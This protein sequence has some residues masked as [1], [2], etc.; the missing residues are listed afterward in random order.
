[1][2]FCLNQVLL[3][4]CFEFQN[5]KKVS[6]NKIQVKK[7]KIKEF[8]NLENISL[9]TKIE[10]KT[11]QRLVIN[12]FGLG[13]VFEQQEKKQTS[14]LQRLRRVG[15][16]NFPPPTEKCLLPVLNATINTLTRFSDCPVK[17]GCKYQP[18]LQSGIEIL[19]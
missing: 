15:H 6:K 1:M 17:R 19:F 7:F 13:Q 5:L 3:K 8:Q 18:L 10:L 4:K 11:L 2:K 14:L 9:L 16:V 12:S